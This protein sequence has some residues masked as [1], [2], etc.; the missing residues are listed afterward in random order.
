M[1]G[2]ND[3]LLD[4]RDLRTHYPVHKGLF[5][6]VASVIKAVDGVSFTIDPKETVGLV[7][8]SGCGKTTIA[9]TIM[10]ATAPTDGQI[11]FRREQGIVDVAEL[12]KPELRSLWLDVQMVFQDPFTS[13][14]P[15][16]TVRDIIGE[17]LR[18]H[19]I[20]RGRAL[21]D[22]VEY[23]MDAVGLN[24]QFMLRYPHA[25]SGGQRQRIGVARAL[26]LNPKLIVADEP[27]SALDV[28]VQAQI[29]N[30]LKDLQDEF[31]VSYLFISH[32]LGVVHHV[33]DKVLI[34]Y[35]GR[36]VEYGSTDAIFRNPRHPYTEMLLA[37]VPNPNPN[38]RDRRK[39]IIPKGDIP[40]PRS[41]PSGCP[42]HTRCIYAQD[43]CKEVTPELQPVDESETHYVACLRY[44]DIELSGL[45]G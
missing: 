6:R 23:L 4:V 1:T 45:T 38:L 41:L 28:S 30:L 37:S 36:L 5:R 2:A 10:R 19:G 40:D 25:F 20:A 15:R 8:E 24:P 14:D 27:T 33:S 22:R 18:E 44:R 42:F 21:D 3:H 7:G 39:R 12:E 34:M 17:A 16:M 11:L 31:D 32:D 9:K 35:V 29:L 13:L 26:A 43:A